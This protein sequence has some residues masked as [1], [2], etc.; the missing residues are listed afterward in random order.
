MLPT[1]FAMPDDSEQK[2]EVSALVAQAT[3]LVITNKGEHEAAQLFYQAIAK[4]KKQIKEFFSPSKKQADELH[5]SICDMESALLT[6]CT[7]AQGISEKKILDYDKAERDRAAK[8]QAEQTERARK[9]AEERKLAEATSLQEAGFPKAANEVLDEPIDI[10][11]SKKVA[12]IAT[13]KGVSTIGRWKV[14]AV[15]DKIAAIKF[16]LKRPEYHN[17]LDLNMTGINQLATTLRENF[18]IPG[19]QVEEAKSLSAKA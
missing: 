17:L 9:E 4:R 3:A 16:L 18:N 10:P 13:V 8:I 5:Q 6:P 2:K 7:Q 12:T 14:T 15:P 19:I 1:P 11:I